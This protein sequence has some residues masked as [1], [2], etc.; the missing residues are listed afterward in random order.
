MVRLG[1]IIAV[2]TALA[3]LCHSSNL[4]YVESIQAVINDEYQVVNDGSTGIVWFNTSGT[5]LD[6][7]TFPLVGDFGIESLSSYNYLQA[8]TQLAQQ[9]LAQEK[10]GDAV[11]LLYKFLYAGQSTP[12]K[13]GLNNDMVLDMIND[14][15]GAGVKRDD[16][17]EAL[18]MLYDTVS[19]PALGDLY[20][21]VSETP[22]QVNAEK[23]ITTTTKCLDNYQTNRNSCWRLIFRIMNDHTRKKSGPRNIEHDGCFISWSVDV[24][25]ELRLLVPQARQC[26]NDCAEVG[27][28]CE[29]RAPIFGS[30]DFKQCLSNRAG[31]CGNSS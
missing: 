25:I 29:A 17:G 22:P 24:D 14:L 8:I 30:F 13:L 20:T 11:F 4:S 10:Y 9:A 5:S 3:E 12:T 1:S 18:Q 19:V 16:L 26:L 21:M 6:R 28:S 15:G 2:A 31:G 23:R 27:I 7:F